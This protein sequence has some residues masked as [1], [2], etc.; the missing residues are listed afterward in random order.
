MNLING[1]TLGRLFQVG[2][3]M[4]LVSGCISA[5][6]LESKLA[7]KTTF[8]P[9]SQSVFEQLVSVAQFY[10][11][12]M[13]I[14]WANGME[15]D[16]SPRPARKGITV[17]GLINT[18]LKRRAGYQAR[19]EN[20][21]LHVVNPVI[22]ASPQNFLNL[23]ISEF[24]VKDANVFG[25][26]ALL[27]LKIDM[28]LHPE[29]YAG[30]YNGGYGSPHINGFDIEN[31]TFSGRNLSVREILNKIVAANGNALW[32]VQLNPSKILNER[33]FAQDDGVEP[34]GFHWRF[35]PLKSA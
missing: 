21:V 19:I 35:I 10:E 8:I 23:R 24:N 11:I 29:R 16:V 25:A 34:A 18:I 5:Q 27:K 17:R 32:I 12:P 28:T 1:S 14:E 7:R 22:G 9:H 3:I 6:S 15:P 4:L 30:G 31:I 20:G 33:F 2:S 26:E 13:G